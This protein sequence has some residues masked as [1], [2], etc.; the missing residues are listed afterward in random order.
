MPRKV[1]KYTLGKTLGEGNESKYAALSELPGSITAAA[2]ARVGALIAR[3]RPS[4]SSCSRSP[5]ALK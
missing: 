5:V 4:L 3:V 1:G 2:A